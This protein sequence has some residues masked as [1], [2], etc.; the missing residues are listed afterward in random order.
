MQGDKII[1]ELLRKFTKASLISIS[2]GSDS[3]K[4]GIVIPGIKPFHATL[5]SEKFLRQ[6]RVKLIPN[7]DGEVFLFLKQKNNKGNETGVTFT[8]PFEGGYL[9]DRDILKFGDYFMQF[10]DP[11]VSKRP[12]EDIYDRMPE[13]KPREEGDN[14]E[15]IKPPETIS[16]YKE[17]NTTDEKNDP[18]K[19]NEYMQTGSAITAGEKSVKETFVKPEEPVVKTETYVPAMFKQAFESNSGISIADEDEEIAIDLNSNEEE[20]KLPVKKVA[21]KANVEEIIPELL[22]LINDEID[23]FSNYETDS[24]S[25]YETDSFSNYETDS[26][27]NKKTDNEKIDVIDKIEDN[28]ET[29]ETSEIKTVKKKVKKMVK[30]KVDSK[31]EPMKTTLPAKREMKKIK[32]EVEEE[33]K[34]EAVEEESGLGFWGFSEEDSE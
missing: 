28:S 10:V 3:Y 6:S 23:S 31:K 19:I 21:F 26:V 34:E 4:N 11:N 14:Q 29:S 25:N 32:E 12:Q 7:K 5:R 17:K 9:Y 13:L 2:I 8:A 22:P 16:A 30:K 20:I 33:V 1:D 24:F 27:L 15:N 18:E